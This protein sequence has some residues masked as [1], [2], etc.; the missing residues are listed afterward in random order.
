MASKRQTIQHIFG[1]GWV[2]D[3]GP[4]INSGISQGGGFVFPYLTTASNI[5]Y[6]PDGSPHKIPGATKLNSSVLA[7][8][9]EI[10]GLFDYWKFGTSGVGVQKRVVHVSTVIMADAAD[11]S[12]SNIQTGMTDNATPCYTLYQGLLIMSNSAGDA[13]Q[14]YDSGT[15]TCANLGGSPPAFQFSTF[16]RQRVWAAGVNALPNTLY[17]S[18]ANNSAQWGGTGTSGSLTIGSLLDG[19]RITGLCSIGAELYVFKGPYYGSIWKVL[20]SSNTGADAFSVSPMP[21]VSGIGAVWH[22]TIFRFRNDVGFMWSDG[23]IHSL[24][25]VINYGA[26]GEPALS[27]PIKSYI[28]ANINLAQ[29]KRCWAVA[30]D[31]RSFALITIPISSSNFPNQILMMDYSRDQ[32]WWSQW[33]AFNACCAARVVDSADSNKVKVFIGG[34]D[35]FVRKTDATDRS[36]DTTD[37]YTATATTPFTNYGSPSISKTL[38]P[39]A[40]SMVPKGNYNMT[41]GVTRDKQAQDTYT[42]SQ[43]ST[44]TAWPF[45]DVF[46]EAEEGGEFKNIQYSV[47]QGIL[48]QDMEVH[49]IMATIELGGEDTSQLPASGT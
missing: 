35:G 41:L 31:A 42:L 24:S 34:Q 22:N 28:D 19:D 43:G 40:V 11:G 20:G 9:A 23:S 33:P 3:V 2:A 25:N 29:L 30:N 7:S 47:S 27:R 12:F 46:T 36:I 48:S 26:Y 10:M 49:A 15:G 6:E 18:S 44:N 21:L 14:T 16:H 39:L 4:S 45:V 37:A 13:P 38:G 32:A 5:F 1:G 8:G 17:Y